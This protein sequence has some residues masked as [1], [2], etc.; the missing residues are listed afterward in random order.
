ME[1][2]SDVLSPRPVQTPQELNLEKLAKRKT[3]KTRLSFKQG[4]AE[5][6]VLDQVT[7][8]WFA[9]AG[10][11]WPGQIVGTREYLRHIEAKTHGLIKKPTLAPYLKED[12]PKVLGEAKCGR[13]GHMTPMEEGVLIG[14][15][16]IADRINDG[17]VRKVVLEKVAVLKPELS[18]NQQQQA[19]RTA[20]AHARQEGHLKQTQV[21]SQATTTAR[22]ACTVEQQWRWHQ[23]INHVDD[24][25]RK[26]NVSDDTGV[27]FME[28]EA[29][30]KVNGDEEGLLACANDGI[31]VYGCGSRD[32]HEKNT[33][34]SR[35]SISLFKCGSSAG[36]SGPTIFLLKGK[37]APVGLDSAYLVRYGGA[38]I[39]GHCICPF[40]SVLHQSARNRP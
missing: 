33:Q 29:A 21:K 31:K 6:A 1:H 27:D 3:K 25:H 10:E 9:K 39:R 22:S 37:K 23:L 5:Y 28:V 34:D 14:T 4:T 24:E 12:N 26:L 19:W 18:R 8:C 30:F 17:D 32:K 35:D 36:W 13:K 11:Y 38:P 40:P 7:K 15:V 20:S 2:A 16:M